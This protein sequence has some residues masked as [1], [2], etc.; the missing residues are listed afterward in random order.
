M[1]Q[2][3]A[4]C[5]RKGKIHQNEK[6][7]TY[8]PY[9]DRDTVFRLFSKYSNNSHS[10]PLKLKA[11]MLFLPLYPL[12]PFPEAAATASVKRMMCWEK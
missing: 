11:S 9:C 10:K 3:V 4:Y 1:K 7:F 8:E 12:P 5:L 2:T 6:S